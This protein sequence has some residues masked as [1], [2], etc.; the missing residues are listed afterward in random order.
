[1]SINYIKNYKDDKWYGIQLFIITLLSGVIQKI[2][3][4][5]FLYRFGCFGI[6]LKNNLNMMIFVKSL[7]YSTLANKDIK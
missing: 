1:M 5:Q 2:M 6:S 4:N 3:Y 7:N